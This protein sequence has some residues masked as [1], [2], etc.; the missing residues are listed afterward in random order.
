MDVGNHLMYGMKKTRF[1]HSVW[2]YWV[3][4]GHLL[5]IYRKPCV[6]MYLLFYVDD[7]I[8]MGSSLKEV[9]N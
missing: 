3:S 1:S 6:T 2:F 5:F 9:E 7:I 8:I 4:N